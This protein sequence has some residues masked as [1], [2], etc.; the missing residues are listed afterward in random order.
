MIAVSAAFTG[1]SMPMPLPQ[2]DDRAVHEVDLGRPASLQVL[3][4][5]GD[6]ARGAEHLGDRADEVLLK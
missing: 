4:H 5:R 2:C 3:T 6:V 1:Q